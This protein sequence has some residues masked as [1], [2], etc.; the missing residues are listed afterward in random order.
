M[1]SHTSSHTSASRSSHQ[2][3]RHHKSAARFLHFI[4][5]L[6]LILALASISLFTVVVPVW[7]ANFFH[8]TGLLRGDWPDALPLLPLSITFL[9][10]AFYLL[11][12][13]HA[14][15]SA[16]KSG[17][18]LK[19]RHTPHVHS[20]ISK[21]PL[22]LTLI[23]LTLLVTF[24]ALSVASGLF[25]VWR[26]SI[27]TSSIE[28]STGASPSSLNL[29]TLS[30]RHVT[31]SVT[32]NNPMSPGFSPPTNGN[33]SAQNSKVTFQ[34]CTLANA[35]TRRCNPTL[36]LLGDLQIAA[37][38]TSSVVWLLN[39]IILV[40]QI[41][42]HRYQKRKLQ[43]SLRAKAKSK[44]GVIEDE[45]GRA[46]KGVSSHP[47]K[48]HHER[49]QRHVKSPSAPSACSSEMPRVTRPVRA[50]TLSNVKEDIDDGFV[51]PKQHYYDPNITPSRSRSTRDPGTESAMASFTVKPLFTGSVSHR[52]GST[53]YSRAVEEARQKV[54]P[55]ESMRD[56]LA[57]RN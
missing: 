38:S 56:W 51:R 13:V 29:A 3:R 41:R 24:L 8:S 43:R 30:L 34:S 26:P 40:L 46:E 23:T 19:S 10:S 57:G 12:L 22:F 45:M 20:T 2:S 21:K 55:A 39:L 52:E 11:R 49:R 31:N 44:L 33:P 18:Y 32:N 16:K 4:H 27:I 42:D 9:T 48:V 17:D 25:R 53:A 47:K 28:L 7:N 35:F 5:S 6:N 14:R 36:F 50:R 37:I 1:D 15:W 54:K